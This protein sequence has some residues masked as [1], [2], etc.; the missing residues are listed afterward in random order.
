MSALYL[1]AVGEVS[2]AAMDWAE[3]AAAD[4]FPYPVRRLPALPI[5]AE[6]YDA[7]RMQFRSVEIMKALARAAPADTAR[8]LGVTEADLSIPMLSFLFGQAQFN[9]PIAVVSLCRL[10]QEYYGLAAQDAL[11]RERLAKEI[12][13]ELGHTFGLVHCADATCAMSLST[14]I[15]LV[16]AKGDRYCARCGSALARRFASNN[17]DSP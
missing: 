14:H 9:G 12:L 6:A 16:D 13:H 1:V 2:P 3:S 11:L 8:L 15:A 4:W 10:R 7:E 5:P 17:G